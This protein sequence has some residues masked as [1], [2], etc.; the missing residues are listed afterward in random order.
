M[1]IEYSTNN[2]FRDRKNHNYKYFEIPNFYFR[3]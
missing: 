1:F 2:Y 3:I